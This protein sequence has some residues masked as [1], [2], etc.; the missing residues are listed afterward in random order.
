[1]DI[2]TVKAL[3][4]RYIKGEAS[5]A[6]QRII[7]QWIEAS[8]VEDNSWDKM[9]DREKEVWQQSL[10]QD[11]QHTIPVDSAA[12]EFTPRVVY[13]PWYRRLYFQVAAAALVIIAAGTA[14]LVSNQTV[15]SQAPLQAVKKAPENDALPGSNK[16]VLTLADGSVVTLDDSG[17]GVLATEGKTEVKKIGDQVIYN[18]ADETAEPGKTSYN[19]LATP[20][21]G[22]YKLVLPDGSKVWLNAASRIKYPVVF[23]KD[24]REVEINGE[25]YFEIAEQFAGKKKIAF[26]VHIADAGGNNKAD[27][28]VLGTHFNINSYDDEASVHTTLLE[29]KVKVL[30]SSGTAES[31]SPVF[32][33]PGEQAQLNKATIKVFKNV[34]VDEVVAWKNGLFLMN[35]A[36]I[37]MVLRQLARWYDVDIEYRNSLP[38]GNISG[39]IPRNLNLSEVLKVLN[40]SGVDF[41]IEGKKII[42]E[43]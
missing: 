4:E 37:P 25:A 26:V 8:G 9:D 35:K 20:K 31:L 3:L 17:D 43:P 14:I 15:P 12:S 6:E 36:S 10:E 40:L 30:K 23:A 7:E 18:S 42:V 5:P 24:K 28:E 34:D 19:V 11:I 41:K 22:Q 13:V 32:L 21:G 39:D 27:V 29:G 2:R 33:A 1:M 38:Q 16:A